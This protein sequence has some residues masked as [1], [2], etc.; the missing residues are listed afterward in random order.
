MCSMHNHRAMRLRSNKQSRV[1]LESSGSRNGDNLQWTLGWVF[2]NNRF[3]CLASTM[4]QSQ[5]PGGG[6]ARGEEKWQ[7]LSKMNKTAVQWG[8]VLHINVKSFACKKRILC[9]DTRAAEK[10]LIRRSERTA[11]SDVGVWYILLSIS[12]LKRTTA[13]ND[14][15]AT[16]VP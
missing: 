5:S 7:L 14:S 3:L 13:A 9:W 8:L 4:I 1:G 11:Y 2:A 16:V 10:W 12:L 15:N 6:G